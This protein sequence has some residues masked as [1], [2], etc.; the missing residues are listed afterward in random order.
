MSKII[1]RTTFS[2]VFCSTITVDDISTQQS[3]YFRN[4]FHFSD[5]HERMNASGSVQIKT[6]C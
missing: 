5:V 3:V 6:S 4:T 2:S 1:D